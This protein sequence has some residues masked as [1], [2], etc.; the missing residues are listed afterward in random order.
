M[1]HFLVIAN[2]APTSLILS[3]L[4][5][6]AVLSPEPSVITRPTRRHIPKD[7]INIH[8]R[9]NIKSYMKDPI[10]NKFH[11]SVS[12]KGLPKV[13]SVLHTEQLA[14]SRSTLEYIFCGMKNGIF[15]DV[16][17]CGS[18]KNRHFGGT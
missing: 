2:T 1:L 13:S 17:P 14:D 8:R 18:C 12:I 4:I 5:M 10:S 16:M 7:G 9:E 15:W 11:I 6:E 3:T